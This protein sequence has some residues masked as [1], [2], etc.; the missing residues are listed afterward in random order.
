[1]SARPLDASARLHAED[2]AARR[3]AQTRF[4]GAL[5]LEA[6]AGTGKTWVL[7][8]RL[9]VWCLGP[10]WERAAARVAAAAGARDAPDEGRV[11]ARVAEG[12][13]A[14]TF[15]EAAA[16]EMH[17][18]LAE[19]LR[20]VRDGCE[21]GL[22]AGRLPAPAQRARRARALLGVL[23]RICISTI[24]AWCRRLLARHPLEAGLHPRFA[25]DADETGQTEAVREVAL[26]W[27]R[28]ALGEAA[29]PDLVELARLGVGPPEIADALAVLVAEGV[30]PSAF[31]ADPFSP[32]R[33][34]AF[35]AELRAELE[36]LRKAGA[37]AFLGG[38]RARSAAAVSAALD[39]SLRLVAGDPPASRAGLEVLLGRLAA[40]WGKSELER[41]GRW[42]AGRLGVEESAL[43]GGRAE[44]LAQWA[45]PARRLLEHAVALRPAELELARRVLPPLLAGV[46]RRL[47]A[48]GIETYQALLRDARDL[49]A[50]HPEVAA[51]ERAVIDQLLVD[52]F[53]DTDAVQCEILR[54]LALEGPPA[55]RPALFLVG[56]PKQ[57]IYG[58]R[59]ADLRAYHR[60]LR[61]LGPGSR[62]RLSLC[63]RCAPA[64]LAEVERAI[65][66]VMRER[67][68]VQPAF[69]RLVAGP[70]RASDPGFGEGGRAP[71]EH[72]V[73]W[74]FDARSRSPDPAL[75]AVA[76]AELE[77]C[78]LAE[79]LREL[80]D[81]HGVA[82]R[83]VACL[84]R[85]SGDFEIYLGALREAEI[86]YVVER[87]A[88]FYQR[89]EVIDA[90]ALLRC[91]LDPHD[92]LALV[93]WLRSAAVGVPDAALVPLW[94]RGLPAR[95]ATL[96]GADEALLAGLAVD[97]AE[98]AAALPPDVPG[99]ERVAGWEQSLVAALEALGRARAAFET[100]PPDLFVE[101]VRE[102]FA[103]EA[104]ESARYLGAYRA[105][106][107]DR[108]FR[109]LVEA[110]EQSGGHVAAVAA[111][112]RGAVCEPRETA[113]G[114]PRAAADDAVQV[115]TIHGAKGLD[116]DHVYLLQHHKGRGR[117]AGRAAEVA[118]R[119]GGL[120]YRLLTRGAATLGLAAAARDARELAAA[121]EVRTLYVAATRARR[122]LVLVGRWP[123]SPPRDAGSHAGLLARRT[124][125]PDL[126]ALARRLAAEGR[127]RAEEAG[128]LWVFPALRPAAGTR[129][130][131]VAAP[132]A[133]LPLARV[134]AESRALLAAREWAGRR[135]ARALV[136]AVSDEELRP[137][138]ALAARYG[139]EGAPRAAGRE[140]ARLVGSAV[141]AALEGLDPLAPPDAA[142]EELLRRAREVAERLAGPEEAA[143]VE[144][145]AASVLEAFLGGPLLERL[146]AAA[147]G[148][149]ARELAVLLPPAD[150]TG[151]VGA[152]SGAIDLLYR[153]GATGE[154]VVV[155]YKTDRVEGAA[156][157]AE[158][159]LAY[160]G[161]GAA[162]T[163]AVAEALGLEP[164]P[165]FEL[166]FLRSGR[167]ERL[168]GAPASR[169]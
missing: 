95:L 68:G 23:D 140:R 44:E 53:Q 119:A 150:G 109:T 22:E 50:R 14:I 58:W 62:E 121:E 35:H 20:A 85:S 46:A 125:A 151:P 43:L 92:H 155:D 3:A 131:A 78:A 61:E 9:A 10:G 77:A 110:L 99:L 111:H 160:A 117:E 90:A 87:D 129:R 107:L 126:A 55:Q 26:A 81:R 64:I 16:A 105:A 124:P 98:V 157:H 52:E 82:W 145:E 114:R 112:L 67:E 34:A 100:D 156:A 159:A 29:H 113:E 139:E 65:E 15:T 69:Q 18:R 94:Q 17:A 71:V 128:A 165:R 59:Q 19:R 39:A 102:L 158:R 40:L 91:I 96:H 130:S 89:R 135:S 115:S 33:V 42:A 137:E 134:E 4:D 24:H 31:E 93:T 142:R 48:Q 167:V 88:S 37:D 152:L 27:L 166:W 6:G 38:G 47:R 54:R 79:D 80:H 164:P 122:R 146:R 97:A 133:P 132:G 28:E 73:S 51:R 25:V 138:E 103:L 84:F 116:W 168:P 49:L 144:G 86:P 123:E 32:E 21:T 162:Y 169:S 56:D 7:V 106:N 70:A 154:W 76:A 75:G 120:E 74:G 83:Q 153:D 12:V 1:V 30:P 41:L 149:A 72:W 141:H 11:A 163:R 136:G 161:Q 57:S 143:A 63:F 5:A 60:F 2:A 127:W 45:A 118:E 66:P 148:I 13:V 104:G 147:P 8:A 101:R 36:G 108:L